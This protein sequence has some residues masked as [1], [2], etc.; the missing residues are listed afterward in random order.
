MFK[1][2]A[3]KKYY[4]QLYPLLNQRYGANDTYTKGQI[5]RTVNE[6]GF[7]EKYAV[8]ALGIFLEKDL[9]EQLADEY[10]DVDLDAVRKELADKFFNGNTEYSFKQDKAVFVG[11]A[12]HSSIG[13]TGGGS[14]E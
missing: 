2:R 8:Y 11:N 12:G 1:N 5:L 9:F 3:I 4:N 7:K 14:G 10:H 13:A 6:C